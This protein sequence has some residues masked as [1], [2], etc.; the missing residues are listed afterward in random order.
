MAD[1]VDLGAQGQAAVQVTPGLV[2]ELSAIKMLSPDNNKMIRSYPHVTTYPDRMTIAVMR[3][4]R[5]M[6]V[7]NTMRV[8]VG[9]ARGPNEEVTVAMLPLRDL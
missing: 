8:I 5:N 1:A 2:L 3:T 9:L 6:M 4:K 7:E